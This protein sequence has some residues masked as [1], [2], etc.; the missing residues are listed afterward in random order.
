MNVGQNKLK[1]NVHVEEVLGMQ[2]VLVRL[3][4]NGV[5]KGNRT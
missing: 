4:G 2:I 3:Y 5:C 1:P